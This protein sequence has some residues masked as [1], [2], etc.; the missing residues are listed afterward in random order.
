MAA[1]LLLAAAWWLLLPALQVPKK[2]RLVAA[3]PGVLGLVLC[4]H[5]IA[6]SLIN[7]VTQGPIVR[8]IA[9]LVDLS[10]PI[11]VVALYQAGL[12][13]LML[14]RVTIVALAVTATSM[15]HQIANYVVAMAL[16]D[17]IWYTSPSSGYLTVAFLLSAATVTVVWWW[18]ANRSTPVSSASHNGVAA[19]V[20]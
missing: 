11:V 5:E 6:W 19:R 12:R 1:A 7:A 8:V 10:V 2:T 3:L 15:V 13:G 16:S 18:Q 4:G 9:V 20:A 14:V 17:A